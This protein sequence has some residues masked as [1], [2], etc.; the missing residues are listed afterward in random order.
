M[1]S[2]TAWRCTCQGYAGLFRSSNSWHLHASHT[3]KVDAALPAIELHGRGECSEVKV[4]CKQAPY[5]PS[6]IVAAADV[7]V[8]GQL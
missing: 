2:S 5:G 7:G 1:E 6:R 3:S 8:I 4:K